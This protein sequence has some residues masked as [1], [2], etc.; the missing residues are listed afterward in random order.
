[1]PNI[2]RNL[3]RLIDERGLKHKAVA[4]AV[5]ISVNQLSGLLTGRRKIDTK[6]LC[7]IMRFLGVDANTIFAEDT[8]SA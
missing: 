3:R 8:R 1:M 7:D 5:G 2:A 6:E 4:E